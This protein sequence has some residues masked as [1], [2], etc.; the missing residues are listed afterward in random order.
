MNIN[1]NPRFFNT[2][3]VDLLQE[4]SEKSKNFFDLFANENQNNLS[5]NTVLKNKNVRNDQKDLKEDLIDKN[6][7]TSVPDIQGI[8]DSFLQDPIGKRKPTQHVLSKIIEAVLLKHPLIKFADIEIK[9]NLDKNNDGS[10]NLLSYDLSGTKYCSIKSNYLIIVNGGNSDGETYSYVDTIFTN[11]KEEDAELA[12]HLILGYKGVIKSI[13]LQRLREL[14]RLKEDQNDVS[15][16]VYPKVCKEKF[17]INSSE[18]LIKNNIFRFTFDK[19]EKGKIVKLGP[20]KNKQENSERVESTT[21]KEDKIEIDP[22]FQNYTAPQFVLDSSSKKWKKE[23]ESNDEELFTDILKKKNEIEKDQVQEKKIE[24]IKINEFKV[25][26][27]KVEEKK[28]EVQK[29]PSLIMQ[30]ESKPKKISNPVYIIGNKKINCKENLGQGNCF[31]YSILEEKSIN[32]ISDRS[33]LGLRKLAADKMKETLDAVV[34]CMEFGGDTSYFY[35]IQYAIDS[36]NQ[37]VQQN[38]NKL[39]K[40]KSYFSKENFARSIKNIDHNLEIQSNSEFK[41]NCKEESCS[42]CD[43]CIKN[44]Y[45]YINELRKDKIIWAEEVSI[46]ALAFALDIDIRIYSA[47]QDKDNAGK[48]TGDK[49]LFSRSTNE[50]AKNGSVNIWFTGG[51]YLYIEKI[52]DFVPVVSRKVIE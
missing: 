6:Q 4:K 52:E 27:K 32:N 13:V 38:I 41:K 22:D 50:N 29:K 7:K 20:A 26:E 11:K 24:E 34:S 36:H 31:F 40:D 43:M 14:L 46:Q 16:N 23:V 30:M 28:I 33:V 2:S 51:H 44:Y 48:P 25:V 3:K 10:Y 35:S 17:V 45:N 49:K 12:M 42:S 9:I 47:S 1:L 19:N 37:S 21:E 15:Q 5:D 8:I 39:N 18:D